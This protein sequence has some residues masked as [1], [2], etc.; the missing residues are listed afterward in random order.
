M[1]EMCSRKLAPLS[2]RPWDSSV[3]D[4]KADHPPNQRGAEPTHAE[5]REVGIE[6]GFRHRGYTFCLQ[7]GNGRERGGGCRYDV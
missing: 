1:G 5:N 7:N 4:V 6:M 2:T 3:T